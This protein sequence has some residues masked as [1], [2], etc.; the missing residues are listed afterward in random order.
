MQAACYFLLQGYAAY[1]YRKR[2]EGPLFGRI[3]TDSESETSF[4]TSSDAEARETTRS[5]A[6]SKADSEGKCNVESAQT[7]SGI[8]SKSSTEIASNDGSEETISKCKDTKTIVS[9]HSNKK[10]SSVDG[11]KENNSGG[12]K[13]ENISDKSSGEEVSNDN[14]EENIYDDGSSTSC[15]SDAHSDSCVSIDTDADDAWSCGLSEDAN[16]AGDIPK[17]IVQLD[18]CT[19]LLDSP[20][21][22]YNTARPFDTE[23]GGK[24]P[25]PCDTEDGGKSPRVFQ[26]A[27]SRPGESSADL[28]PVT[29]NIFMRS[30]AFVHPFAGHDGT[31]LVE[32]G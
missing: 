29:R 14:R 15:D 3:P 17:E 11:S 16:E 25:R 4:G 22:M 21:A 13:T 9:N 20:R 27:P 5:C 31:V 19:S 12:S 7:C 18:G 30:F 26:K 1:L 10:S 2:T 28:K 32:G 8:T 23:D 6:P 24:S